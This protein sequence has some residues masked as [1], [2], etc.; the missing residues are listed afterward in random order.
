MWRGYC[1]VNCVILICIILGIEDLFKVLIVVIREDRRMKRLISRIALV[2]VV[3]LAMAIGSAMAEPIKG[4]ATISGNLMELVGLYDATPLSDFNLAR[5]VVIYSDTTTIGPGTDDLFGISLGMSAAGATAVGQ[6]READGTWCADAHLDVSRVGAPD[7]IHF[8]LVT[9]DGYLL[10][11]NSDDPQLL[12]LFG[13]GIASKDGFEDTWGTWTFS[14]SQDNPN[15]I[16]LSWSGSWTSLEIPVVPEP[17]TMLLL[18]TGL[19]GIA[20]LARRNRK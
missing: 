16:A 6:F 17:T 9:I 14:T 3:V 20:A 19:L 1:M 2:A 4:G 13:T 5:R 12:R 7:G 11:G 15:R 10:D 18:G 8:R